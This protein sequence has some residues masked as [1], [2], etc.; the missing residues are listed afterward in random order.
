LKLGMP[1]ILDR[2]AQDAV[3]T[4]KSGY[5]EEVG[6]ASTHQPRSLK[7]ALGEAKGNPI[8]VEIKAASPSKG[9]FHKKLN[10]VKLSGQMIKGGAA[11]LSVL[12]EPKH[13]KGSIRYVAEISDTCSYPILM[14][15]FILSEAQLDAAVKAGA[16]AV[17]LIQTLFDRGYGEVELGEMISRAHHKNLEVLLETHTVDEFKAGVTS[18]ADLIGINN[19]DLKTLVTDL[20]VTENVLREGGH[21]SKMV[22][23]ESGVNTVDDIRFLRGCGADAFLVGSAVMESIDPERKVREL[24]EA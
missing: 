20:R 23:S 6:K 5:Y 21:P 2:L 13:F 14:K 18:G 22:V 4:I 10:P 24:V 1:D 3:E 7:H 15:D 17:L 11:G 19:R 9:L 12:T 8:I 16:S